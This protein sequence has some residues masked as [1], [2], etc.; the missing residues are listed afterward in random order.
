VSELTDPALSGM[1]RD[2]TIDQPRFSVRYRLDIQGLRAIA[3]LSVIAFHAGLPVRAGFLGVDVFF[4][5][6][7]FVITAMLQRE[8]LRHGRISFAR[9]Y[10]R[11]FKRLAPALA[12]MVSV[13]M[14]LTFALLSPFGPQ[15][16]AAATAAGAMFSVSNVV[17]A[18]TTGGYFDASAETNPLLNTWSLSVEEQFYLIFPIVLACSW[19][20]ASP[21]RR[22]KVGGAAY[23]TVGAV[24][25]GSLALV[26]A[27][28][29]GKI[30]GSPE[31]AFGFY[32]PLP[33]AWEFA[34]GSL[35]A[36][37][38]ANRP[39]RGERLMPVLGP[40]GLALLLSSFWIVD[41]ATTTFP[42]KW[43]ILP[44]AGTLLVLFAGSSGTNLA[45]HILSTRPLVSIGDVSY[46]L[47]LWHWPLIVFAII[48]WPQSPS[49]AL[50]AALLSFAPALAS[51][52]WLEQPIRALLALPRRRMAV[53]VTATMFPPLLLAGVVS[54]AADRFWTPRY[55]SGAMP[56][57]N[58]GDVGNEEFFGFISQNFYPCTPESI[59]NRALYWESTAR[60]W[61]SKPGS[62]VDIAL[63]GDSHAEH[64]FV[65]LAE[66][67][68]DR[69]IAYY[70]LAA[71]PTRSSGAWMSTVIDYVA[72]S[73]TIDTVIVNAWWPHYQEIPIPALAST[74]N[75]FHAS[76][77]SVFIT[78]DIPDYTFDAVRCKYQAAPL[79]PF[80][81]CAEDRRTDSERAALFYPSLVA[82]VE[83]APGVR[84]LSTRDYFCDAGSCSMARD[85][86]LLYRDT[87]H[88]NL[89]GSRFLAK[90]LLEGNKS[91]KNAVSGPGPRIG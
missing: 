42:G 65:G 76:G 44:V 38:L 85:G 74:L 69:N 25:L 91:F 18:M 10:S 39:I 63:V 48:L 90:R 59:R 49:V 87:N 19:F 14:V 79:L 75:E 82:A 6:S 60:C 22:L 53:L 46:S 33:R 27:A 66:E 89:D 28:A 17:I 62:D 12:L 57:A 84:L 1:G 37:F 40:I 81:T 68:P 4:V 26:A 70:I 15:Q 30:S 29:L 31:G 47:Y 78:D 83:D 77:K 23:I 11:R 86:R 3:V 16:T 41:P 9:F 72:S 34:V 45:T 52:R 7:G 43:T 61:Q 88:L 13:T 5:I 36:L 32:S 71:L 64:L 8:W 50:V 35:L 56:V 20:L 54:V 67:L 51:Y 58:S 73:K 55:A 80:N 24:A 2:S 21:K